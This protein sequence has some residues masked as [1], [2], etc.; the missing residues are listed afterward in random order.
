MQQYQVPQ[1][2]NVQDKIIGPFTIKQA[3]WVGAGGGLIILAK[4]FF[5]ALLFW[6][7]A[8]FIGGFALALAFLKINMQPFPIIVKNAIFFFLKPRFYIW[9]KEEARRTAATPEIPAKKE[10]LVSSLPKLTESKLSDL[11]WSLDVKT[12]IKDE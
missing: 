4:I 3:L 12:R 9:K 6:P 5:P 7:F 1:F 10:T 11:A 2:I 8:I